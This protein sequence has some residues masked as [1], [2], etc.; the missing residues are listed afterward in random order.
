MDASSLIRHR[1]RELGWEQKDLA[2]AAQVTESYISQLLARKKA[3]PAPGRTD[4]YDRI[5]AALGLPGGQLSKL[6]EQQ[7]REEMRRKL[8]GTPRPLFPECRELILSRCPAGLRNDISRIFAKDPFGEAER[9][10]AKILLDSARDV[11]PEPLPEDVFAMAEDLRMRCLEAAVD[12]WEIDLKT[13]AVTVVVKSASGAGGVRRFEYA[14]R[15]LRQ[16]AEPG[17]E[18]FLKDASLSG[19]ATAEEIEF[20]RGL[21]FGPRRPTALYFYRELQ[22]LRDPLHFAPADGKIHA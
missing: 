20:L 7:R 2:A 21:K 6:A 15:D 3:P 22:S 16:S 19:D 9:M 10:I 17:L 14:E 8:S 18:Q 13:F 4:I 11:A 12:S 5:G 1:L